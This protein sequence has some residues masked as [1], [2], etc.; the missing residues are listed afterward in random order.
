[1]NANQNTDS[2][3][4]YRYKN[5][6]RKNKALGLAIGGTNGGNLLNLAAANGMGGSLSP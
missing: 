4:N 1:M 5:N 6:N 3:E 2:L